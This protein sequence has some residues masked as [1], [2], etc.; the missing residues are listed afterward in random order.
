MIL[1]KKSVTAAHS[2]HE[3]TSENAYTYMGAHIKEKDGLYTYVFRTFAPAADAVF[4]VGDFCDWD[5]GIPMSRITE[6]GIF[7]ASFSSGECFA[8]A[9]YKFRVVSS[10]GV[11]DKGDPYAFASKGG[12][13]GASIL[14]G[15][16]KFPWK[17]GGWMRTRRAACKTGKTLSSPL[18]IY[19]VHL[20]S[21]MRGEGNSYLTYEEL[22]K[23][24]LSYVKYM[25]YTHIELLPIAEYP[26]DDSWG[27]QV[28]AFYA[29]TGRFGTPDEFRAFVSLMHEGGVGVLLDWV[30]AH[31]PKDGW[32]LYEFDGGPLYEYASPYRWESPSWGTRYFDLG[33]REV[34]SFLISNALYWLREFHLDGL[35]VDAVSSMLYLDYDRKAGE[36]EPNCFGTNRN[37]EAEAFLKKLNEAVHRSFP[38]CLMIAEESTSYPGV[39]AAPQDGGLGFDLKWNMGFANDLYRYLESGQEERSML[40]AALNFPITYAFSEKYVLPISHDE[41]VHG[42]RSFLNK[43]HG[44]YEEKFKTARASLLFYM[45]FPG[46]K[47]LFMGSEYGQFAEWDF[48]RSLEW[49]MLEYEKHDAFREYVAA[50]NRFYLSNPALHEIDFCENGFRWVFADEANRRFVA[51]R[52]FSEGGEEILALISFSAEENRGLGI[53]LEGG[54]YQCVFS[55][56]DSGDIPYRIEGE[57]LVVDLPPL[58]GVIF[59]RI[60]KERELSPL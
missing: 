14:T 47:L 17:D 44:S 4:V 60:E 46:K 8:G 7:E 59:K 1:N 53:D 15:K 54:S 55:T 18:N 48:R 56:L 38:D 40:H 3:G 12:S 58:T 13:D 28:G 31:F 2:F 27:Y 36:W 19:E 50:L 24:L 57:R 30:G 39:T 16:S 32:G 42:K 35:R 9:S 41:V 34:Q 52:R 6:K 25:G 29:P 26:F 21:F 51:Y 22:A 10:K 49:F 33:R 37:L 43:M 45:T 20:G 23:E 5:R 11:Q